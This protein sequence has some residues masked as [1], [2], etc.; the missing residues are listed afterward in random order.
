MTLTSTGL[1][2][3]E[4]CESY[5]N[6]W[7]KA[8]IGT[9][10]GDVSASDEAAHSGSK[11]FAF[12]TGAD[13]PDSGYVKL[14]KDVDLLT[15]ANR[16]A[17]CWR[18]LYNVKGGAYDDFLGSSLNQFGSRW[19]G[20]GGPVSASAYKVGDA[21]S[22]YPIATT[23]Q[24]R[25]YGSGIIRLGA[26]FKW[27]AS[28]AQLT[29]RAFQYPSGDGAGFRIDAGTLYAFV[30]SESSNLGSYDQ[31]HHIYEVEWD[32]VGGNTY[33]YKDGS[34]VYSSAFSCNDSDGYLSRHE[35]TAPAGTGG[36][37]Y[38]D[39]LALSYP[40]AHKC[41]LKLGTQTLFDIDPTVDFLAT[42]AAFK[43]QTAGWVSVTPTGSQTI[44][45]K[46]RNASGYKQNAPA[47]VFFDD[48]VIMFDTNM[49]IKGLLGGQK[50][51]LYDSG[52]TLRKTGTCP[53]TGTDVV[54][55]GI[56]ALITTAYGLQ[57]YFKVYDTDGTTLLYTGPTESRWGGDICTWLPNQSAMDATATPTQIYRTGS[58]LTPTTSTIKVTLTDK[59][60][61][62]LLSGKTVYWTPSLGTCY[63]ADSDTDVNGEATTAFT[64]GSSAGLGG[65]RGDFNGDATY[66]ASQAQSLIDIYHAQPVIDAT[67]DF[68]AF[69]EGQ[70]IVI[71][72]GHY[73]LGAEFRPQSF[74]IITP[75]MG[76]VIGGWWLVEIYRY[77]VLEF[78]GRVLGRKQ[79]S[80]ASPQLTILGVDDKITLQRRACNKVYTDE[81]QN[82]IHDLLTRYPC[83]ISAGTIALYGNTIKLDATYEVL[84]DALNQIANA[85]GWL[86]R[87][88]ANRT[89]D[90][91]S[92]F[93]SVKAVTVEFGVNAIMTNNDEDWSQLNSKVIVLGKGAGGSLLVS[94]LSDGDTELTF[95]L[96]EQPFLE[97]NISVQGTLDLRAAELLAEHKVV[98]QTITADFIDTYATDTYAPYDTITIT[99]AETGLSG[100][101]Q[102]HSVKRD[103]GNAEYAGLAVTNAII[104]IAD[105]LQALRKDVKDLG[106]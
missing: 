5:P 6:G 12:K 34:L 16:V 38:T 58:G 57:S 68:Q 79:Q 97:K 70:D 20:G 61:G 105:A 81:P 35:K 52:G 74:D 64:A 21:S 43:D 60:T 92:S 13:W 67:K 9:T 30:T 41:S 17:R 85:T 55:T 42:D 50:V 47:L 15:G 14:T 98:R 53:L 95:G 24:F 84:M 100:S 76:V 82:I 75:I 8:I 25:P 94:E 7:T 63:P 4:T 87:L 18:G 51:E 36:D 44:E 104:T 93:G 89:L 27:G 31:N 11:S 3:A 32:E 99:D 71:V 83:G 78:T 77:G 19:T 28:P 88:N 96:I 65:V 86:F 40:A 10:T 72:G 49:T 80:G 91:G 59:D 66:G 102:V 39:W 54:F 101:Y 48:L 103:L 90:F 69:I 73:V 33:F 26:R 29:W 2:L 62:G 45:L 56:D 37:Y 46:V 1:I 23:S 106:I 22:Y